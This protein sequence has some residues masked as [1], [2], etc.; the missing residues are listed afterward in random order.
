[1]KSMVLTYGNII[2]Y[3][4]RHWKSVQYLQDVVMSSDLGKSVVQP[5]VN[6]GEYP[7]LMD[8]MILSASEEYVTQIPPQSSRF[9]FEESTINCNL[10]DSDASSTLP[11][12]PPLH[13]LDTSMEIALSVILAPSSMYLVSV[14]LKPKS[15]LK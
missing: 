11:Q 3:F 14:V 8:N 12:A 10:G 6:M 13:A 7:V 2:S 4:M 1:M 5:S 15:F 9:V